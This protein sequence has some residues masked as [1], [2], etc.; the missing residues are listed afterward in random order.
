LPIPAA[1]TSNFKGTAIFVTA[2]P[3]GGKKNIAITRF[4]FQESTVARIR[5]ENVILATNDDIAPTVRPCYQVWI[6]MSYD[7]STSC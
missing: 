7:C 4:E 5:S 3:D 6:K 1:N 2:I